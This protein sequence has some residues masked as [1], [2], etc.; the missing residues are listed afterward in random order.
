[1][2]K[3]RLPKIRVPKRIKWLIISLVILAGLALLLALLWKPLLLW[4]LFPWLT[5]KLV[6]STGMNIWLARAFVIPALFLLIYAI[7]LMFSLKKKKRIAGFILLCLMISVVSLV[8]YQFTKEHHFKFGTGESLQ[9]YIKTPQGFRLYS[10]SGYDVVTGEKLKKV[11]PEIAKEIEIWKREKGKNKKYEKQIGKDAKQQVLKKQVTRSVPRRKSEKETEY[12]EYL[13]KAV[14]NYIETIKCY[15]E[16]NI[17]DREYHEACVPYIRKINDALFQLYRLKSSKSIDVLIN[18]WEKMYRLKGIYPEALEIVSTIPVFLAS[19]STS[20]A[21]DFIEKNL[22][23]IELQKRGNCYNGE[24]VLIKIVDTLGKHLDKPYIQQIQ[25]K[26]LLL[27][28]A[29]RASSQKA[30]DYATKILA[31]HKK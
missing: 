5:G 19:M 25:I 15:L 30:R 13:D 16:Y 31:Q 28:I 9:W 10:T 3:I 29:N 14:N 18:T 7:G 6:S 24:E 4:Q 21:L 22:Y 17:F 20:R 8:M 2:K 27:F 12:E 1:M 23:E 26:D 11:T